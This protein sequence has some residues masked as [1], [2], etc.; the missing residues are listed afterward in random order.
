MCH[1]HRKGAH[2]D[3]GSYIYRK[4]EEKLNRRRSV[5]PAREICKRKKTKLDNKLPSQYVHTYKTF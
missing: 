5:V 1:C 3:D 4:E 2:R